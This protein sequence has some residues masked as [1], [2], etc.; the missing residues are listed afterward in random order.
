MTGAENTIPLAEAMNGK[1]RFKLVPFD[2]IEVAAT[3][4]Y[5]IKDII[6]REALVVAWGP[7]K[8]G[9]SF[10]TFDAL[11]H[12]ALGW[13]YRCRRITQG[14]VVYVA[15][16]GERGIG[17]RVEAYRRRHLAE[18]HD[19]VPFYVVLTRLNL[20]GEH[21]A[22]I[23]DIRAQL[24]DVRPVAIAIDTLNR[25][26]TGSE[27]R[28]EDMSA[29]VQA[30][31]AVREAFA[32][33][34]FLIHHCG[35]DG[36]RPRGHTSLTGACDTQLAVKRGSNGVV[37]VTVEYM[38]DGSEGDVIASRLEVVDVGQDQ[39]GEAITSC[40]IVEADAAEAK[41]RTTPRQR[42]AL[43]VLYD[44]LADHGNA[45]PEA[46]HYPAGAVVVDVDLW[47]ETLFSAGVLD[48]NANNPRQ[49]FKRLK[50]GLAERGEI[51]EWNGLVWAVR[52]ATDAGE[53]AR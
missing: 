31:D 1:E 35:I 38:K 51:A 9:K 32:C 8:C 6:P 13:E 33:T 15:C 22:L 40:V 16:E 2:K 27:S 42:R 19:F 12:V 3:R 50:D 47:R 39:D 41:T 26:L 43:A 25:S 20:I 37:T 29:Y 5:L 10:W 23:A 46:D 34:I 18:D 21:Q 4:P 45:A 48:A 11:M 30:A 53:P 52:T 44:V 28:D 17:A 24:D 7:P 36:T 49:P 14:P